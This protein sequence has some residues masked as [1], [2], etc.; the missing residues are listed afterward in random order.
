[1]HEIYLMMAQNRIEERI[2]EAAAWRRGDE[3]RGPR[4]SI[5]WSTRI[6]SALD[7]SRVQSPA[8]TA[9]AADAGGCA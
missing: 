1:M 5:A 6:R 8:G 7:R 3:A 9:T 2:R 4:S